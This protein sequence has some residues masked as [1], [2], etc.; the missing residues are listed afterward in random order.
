M[1]LARLV[2][3]CVQEFVLPGRPH[4][5]AL[6]FPPPAKDVPLD[7]TAQVVRPLQPVLQVPIQALQAPLVPAPARPALRGRPHW[8]ALQ[9]PHLV[10]HVALDTHALVVWL[11]QLVRQAPLHHLPALALVRPALSAPTAPPRPQ[12]LRLLARWELPPRRLGIR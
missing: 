1:L 6:P 10:R 4:W 3:A 8:Q 5:Q 11:L 12:R 9:H 2:Q 7:T